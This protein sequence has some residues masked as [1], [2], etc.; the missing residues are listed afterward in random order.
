[1]SSTCG[2]L[3]SPTKWYELHSLDDSIPLKG[4]DHR[5]VMVKETPL[6]VFHKKYFQVCLG[7]VLDSGDKNI[8][9]G[10]FCDKTLVREINGGM[11]DSLERE[12]FDIEIC[13]KIIQ[14]KQAIHDPNLWQ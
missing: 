11:K 14:I 6:F 2:D 4:L 12:G 1:M 7:I 5:C 3:E 9:W 13:L 8:R 10:I